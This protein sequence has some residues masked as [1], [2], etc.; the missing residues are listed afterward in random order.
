[1]KEADETYIQARA[2]GRLTSSL[3]GSVGGQAIRRPDT[4]IFG[5]AMGRTIDEGYPRS[6][7][8]QIIQPIY[9]GGRVKALK[10]Q[11]NAGIMA[12][13]QNLRN[14][15]QNLLVSAAT[16]YV[17]VL[18]DE[19]TARIRRNNVSVLARQEQAARDRFDVGEGTLTDI[20][21]SQTRLTRSLHLPARLMNVLSG[22]RLL[23]YSLYRIL[24]CRRLYMRRSVLV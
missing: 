13:R 18:R 23:I 6:T 3:S 21:Q 11:A 22:I 16:A 10:R 17:D 19:E 14:A 1:M 2:Q 24:F 5:A 20:A 9:Q 4:N 7:Q 15:E 8:L 12:A